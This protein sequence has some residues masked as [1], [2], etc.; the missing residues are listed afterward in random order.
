MLIRRIVDGM[1][2]VIRI[3]VIFLCIVFIGV[4]GFKTWSAKLVKEARELEDIFIDLS[5]VEDGTYEGHSELGPVIVDVK[6]TVKKG[7]I[8]EIEIVNHQ[9]GLGQS[10]NVI[11][12]EM[13]DKNTYD[14]DAVSG[15]T[16]SSEIIMNAVN[17]ALQKGVK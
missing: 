8:E 9:N 13:V 15:A 1:K 14:V 2:K 5:K 3:A 10:A 16:V 7:K 4:V 6:V 12:D 17:N 11:V